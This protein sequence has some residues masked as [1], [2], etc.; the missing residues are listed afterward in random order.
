MKRREAKMSKGSRAI[1]TEARERLV[2]L[3]E[4][5]GRKDKA[6]RWRKTLEEAEAGATRP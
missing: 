4:A 1:L 2:R 5:T 3:D 6:D